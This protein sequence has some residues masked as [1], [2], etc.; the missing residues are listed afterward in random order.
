MT[1][2][3]P[4]HFYGCWK[5]YITF[6]H[7]MSRVHHKE[8][9]PMM[10]CLQFGNF[11]PNMHPRVLLLGAS[12]SFT[13]CSEAGRPVS[14][15]IPVSRLHCT[16]NIAE[17]NTLLELIKPAHHEKL[18]FCLFI[19]HQYFVISMSDQLLKSVSFLLGL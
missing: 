3:S 18:L 16:I 15:Q 7:E 11:S 8:L 1:I 4:L 13:G 14:E 9:F 10:L 17:I 12:K 5:Q 19:R 2:E 6:K